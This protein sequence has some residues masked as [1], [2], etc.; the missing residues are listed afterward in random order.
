MK[1]E[2]IIKIV[3]DL[4]FENLYVKMDSDGGEYH[5][6]EIIG[7]TDVILALQTKLNQLNPIT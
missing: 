7:I 1:N 3:E 5:S 4:M 6:A 2:E